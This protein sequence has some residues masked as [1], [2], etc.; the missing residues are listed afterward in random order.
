MFARTRDWTTLLPLRKTLFTLHFQ[1]CQFLKQYV[2]PCIKCT[3]N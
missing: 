1:L 3:A 2:L